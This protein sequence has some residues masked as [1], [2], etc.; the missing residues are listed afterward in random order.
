MFVTQWL[1]K[2]AEFYAFVPAVK[3]PSYQRKKFQWTSLVFWIDT[4]IAYLQ[5]QSVNF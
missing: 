5:V 4:V 3:Q 2:K 1:E